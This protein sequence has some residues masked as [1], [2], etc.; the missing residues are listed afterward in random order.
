MKNSSSVFLSSALV[1][2]HVWEYSLFIAYS[3]ELCRVKACICVEKESWHRQGCVLQEFRRRTYMKPSHCPTSDGYKRLK[4]CKGRVSKS[5]IMT[6]LQY[7]HFGFS[8]ISSTIA[9]SSSRAIRRAV[10]PMQ[11]L[12][13]VLLNTCPRMFFDQIV[14]M[15][16]QSFSLCMDINFVDSTKIPVFHKLRRECNRVDNGVAKGEKETK[17]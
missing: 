6:I 11:C 5:E 13:Q 7:Y 10:F 16:I 9:C 12:T 8:A 14:F 3:P 4:Y 1:E 2:G 15:R 17:V